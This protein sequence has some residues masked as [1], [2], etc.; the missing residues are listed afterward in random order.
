M[1]IELEKLSKEELEKL[2]R[3]LGIRLSTIDNIL[4]RQAYGRQDEDEI[5]EL[6]EEYEQIE[7][8]LEKIRG[9]LNN[10]TR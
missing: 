5:T 2:R 1:K 4:D 7:K 3:E 10:K 9:L 8:M 6:E